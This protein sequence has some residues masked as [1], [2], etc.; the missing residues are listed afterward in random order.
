MPLQWWYTGTLGKVSPISVE[1]LQVASVLFSCVFLKLKVIRRVCICIYHKI[2]NVYILKHIKAITKKNMF[3]YDCK[4]Y[5]ALWE[6]L[7]FS[8]GGDGSRGQL[9]RCKSPL[10]GSPLLKSK[11]A[12]KIWAHIFLIANGNAFLK[13]GNEDVLQLDLKNNSCKSSLFSPSLCFFF[14]AIHI[15]L[16]K[17]F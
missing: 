12:S 10:K 1:F 9:V 17:L 13:H 6:A 15:E 4:S 5:S 8:E 2:K 3:F 7:V 16:C 11:A 14:K